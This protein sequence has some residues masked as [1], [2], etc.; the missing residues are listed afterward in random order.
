[1]SSAYLPGEKASTK[2]GH[3]IAQVHNIE[4]KWSIKLCILRTKQ[5]SKALTQKLVD[6]I[7]K[8]SNVC[9][10]PIAR[11]TLLITNAES[12]VK[13]RVPKLLLECSMWKLHNELNAS[14]YDGVLLGSRHVNT[15][16][17]ISSD[18]ILCSLT[19]P[20]LHPMTDHHKMICGCSIC[21]T[22]KYFQES[23]NAWWR[24]Q[25]KTMKYKEDNSCGK[26]KY[27]LNQSYK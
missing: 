12:G 2:R 19:S 26:K 17:V 13:R 6:W 15:N 4:V 21:N 10:S 1:M 7:M 16:D 14:P 11:D 18:T 9:E 22:A 8:N 25:L 27:E 5:I 20:Q 23:I 24:K 3:F